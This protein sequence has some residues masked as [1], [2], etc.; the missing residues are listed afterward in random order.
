MRL[1]AFVVL[2]GVAAAADITRWER[3]GNTLRFRLTAGAAEIEWISTSSFRIARC[4][5]AP[6][7]K[8][9]WKNESV[10]FSNTETPAGLEMKTRYV[11]ALMRKSGALLDVRRATGGA[12]LIREIALGRWALAA[13]ERLY[14]LGTRD[15]EALD[16]RGSM[17]RA[18]LPLAVSTQGYGLYFLTPATPALDLGM[19]NPGEMAVAGG[20]GAHLEYFAYY[21]PTPKE[22]LEEHRHV[23]G[24]L[25]AIWVEHT[26]VPAEAELPRY[27]V[28]MA[29]AEAGP[30]AR[31][32]QH[33]AFSGVLAPA[34]ELAAAPPSAMK[35]APWLPLVWSSRPG[36]FEA[37]ARA[38]R[39]WA[40]YLW[41]YLQEARDRGFPVIRPLA[42]QYPADVEAA[43]HTDSFVIGDEMLVAMARQVYLPMGVW[44]DLATGVRH[45]GR[46]MADLGEAAELPALLAKNGAILPLGEFGKDATIE[47]HYF[48]T[49]AAEFFIYEPENGFTSQFHAAPAGD[50]MRLEI[51]SKVARGYKWV[52]YDIPPIREV[53]AGGT[54]LIRVDT[55]GNIPPGA[56]YYDA[57]RRRLNVRLDVGAHAD[58]VVNLTFQ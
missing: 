21:G 56:W 8:K 40:P 31:A 17:V 9:V 55:Q 24:P 54:H 34:I 14:G 49:L 37:V 23:A 42:M 51:E 48:P 7:S 46:R 5:A 58:V 3:D 16:L 2:T 25:D 28:R 50:Y 13:D 18:T 27:A 32:L 1:A 39:R 44:T 29:S 35:M 15:T 11:H 19:A 4:P 53:V 47:L 26:G 36:E 57:A 12:A 45:P 41:T 43:R 6:C 20:A 30:L 33:A 22:V 10:E 52:V 38:R